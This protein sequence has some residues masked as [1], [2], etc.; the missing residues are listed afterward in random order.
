MNA[1]V[2]VDCQKDFLKG[3]A[4]AFGYPE[5]DNFGKVLSFVKEAVSKP[6]NK[7][8]LTRDTHSAG[9]LETLEGK[10]LP[11]KHCIEMSA[12]WMVDERLMDI[13][14]DRGTY[15]NK[16]TFGSISLVKCIE[17]DIGTPSKIT[18]CGYCSS[19]CVLANAV[20]LRARFPNTKISVVE[21]ACGDVSKE[22]HDA[23]MTVLK[24]QQIEV[25]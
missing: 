24:M 25:M 17:E 7:V 3:G 23:A 21:A 20:L 19:I 5:E 14:G 6:D 4:L 12:G 11:V 10:N 16:P 2:I 18:L 9:Y 8:Y 1:V 22:A 13:I 15:V